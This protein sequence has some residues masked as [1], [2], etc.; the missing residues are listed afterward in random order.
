MK[1]SLSYYLTLFVI[2]LKGIK[3]NFSRDPIDFKT[4]RK[5]DVHTPKGR[6]F[7][8][9]KLRTFNV[10]DSLI[11]EIGVDKNAHQL[12]IFIHGGAFISGPAQHHWDSVK[13]I[14]KQ[15]KHIIWMCD[16]PKAPENQIKSISDNIDAIYLKALEEYGAANIRLLGDSVGGTLVTTLVQRL[17]LGKK[18]LPQK[19]IL[20]TPV[21]DAS[22]SNPDIEEIEKSDPMLSPKGVLSAKKMCVGNMDLSNKMISPLHGSFESFPSTTL[23]LAQNDI[24]YPDGKLAEEKLKRTN[25]ELE[26]FEGNDMPH[27]WPLLPVMSEAKSSL[28]QVI[29]I[30]KMD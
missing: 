30:L 19:I 20:V 22:M 24:M 10:L 28:Q 13:A 1:H 21:M 29:N 5:E 26:V 9:N 15:T 12:L 25:A 16:Y 27:I 18:A 7:R 17:V 8:Q 23:F 2:K 14:A 4:I 3:N 11:T 6:F